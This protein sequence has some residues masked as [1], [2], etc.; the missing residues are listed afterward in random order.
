MLSSE[1]TFTP[2]SIITFDSGVDR[3][4]QLLPTSLQP[5]SDVTLTHLSFEVHSL[6]MLRPT[7]FRMSLRSLWLVRMNSLMLL[8]VRDLIGGVRTTFGVHPIFFVISRS[9]SPCLPITSPG[10]SASMTTSPTSG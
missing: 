1:P 2:Q 8:T 6:W 9:V 7:V 10:F 3:R 5:P 4:K